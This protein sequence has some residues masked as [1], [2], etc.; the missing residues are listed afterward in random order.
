[1]ETLSKD[2]IIEIGLLLSYDDIVQFGLTCKSVLMNLKGIWK[3]KSQ[4]EFPDLHHNQEFKYS[5]IDYNTFSVDTLEQQRYLWLCSQTSVYY[6]SEKYKSLTFCLNQALKHK[7]RNMVTFFIEKGAK[8][9]EDSIKPLFVYGDLDLIKRNIHSHK[10]DSEHKLVLKTIHTHEKLEKAFFTAAKHGHVHI[11]EYLFEMYVPNYWEIVKYRAGTTEKFE[12]YD[13]VTPSPQISFNMYRDCLCAIL[14]GTVKGKQFKLFERFSNGVSYERAVRGLVYHSTKTN[15]IELLFKFLDGPGSD[16]VIEEDYMD[17]IIKGAIRGKR[18]DL[19]LDV[20]EH[21]GEFAKFCYDG[22]I[23][24]DYYIED[25]IASDDTELILKLLDL[26]KLAQFE[27]IR[28]YFHMAVENG[29][30]ETAMALIHF[31]RE[32]NITNARYENNY[33]AI[34]DTTRMYRRYIKKNIWQVVNMFR[35]LEKTLKSQLERQ[36]PYK[37]QEK[38]QKEVEK[39]A[40]KYDHTSIMQDGHK[41]FV[42]MH[43]EMA[44]TDT[45]AK[46]MRDAVMCSQLD[47][48][49]ICLT[50]LKREA[51]LQGR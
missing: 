6:G 11:L 42:L 26:N 44:S 15:Q 17:N 45:K 3:L 38:I 20:V 51:R 9:D 50:K 24:F 25:C 46:I 34:F 41:D 18:K 7:N 30:C 1:M 8:C 31:A 22:P 35:E 16:F 21:K 29:S 32:R 10:L 23:L 37:R 28:K 47:V 33:D 48:I 4:L 36:K 43:F 19:F 40:Y 39:Y 13:G 14:E 2:L 49:E 12:L 5:L 27:N